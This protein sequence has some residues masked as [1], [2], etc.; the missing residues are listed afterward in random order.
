LRAKK[1]SIVPTGAISGLLLGGVI[2]PAV[3]SIS[4]GIVALALYR[5]AFDI[6]VGVLIL[7]FAA[8]AA[9]GGIVAYVFVRKSARLAEMQTD[10][11]ANVSHELRTPLAG[12]HLLVETLSLGRAEAPEQ[13]QE[14]LS[15]LAAEVTRLEDLV[16]RILNWRRLEAGVTF[17]A[18]PQPV[19][20]LLDEAVVSV[21]TAA[22]VEHDTIV[23][24]VADDLPMVLGD[25]E[26]LLDAFRNLVHNAVK[27]GGDKGPVEV[28]AR[29]DDG[30]V[31]VE[32]RDRGPGI[33][34]PER[35]RI[36]DR[37]YRAPTDTPTR[38]GTGL[39]LAIVRRVIKGH[40]GRL[41]VEG[42]PGEGAIFVVRL[43]QANN[44]AP[45]S[46]T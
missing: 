26:A 20:E 16:A 7:S 35:K 29:K 28:V 21:A 34:A 42:E 31:V 2:I 1:K 13:R 32:V 8:T 25:R 44:N 43:P 4:V 38:Q 17:P 39:G 9:T 41:H 30:H 6:V 37:F 5:E 22:G 45:R 18:T 12:I 40:R 33:P 23:T 11:I 10:F 19:A 36:F 15:R 24:T 46:S 3:L 14:V 27:F